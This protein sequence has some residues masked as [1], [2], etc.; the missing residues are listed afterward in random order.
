MSR[1]SG[2]ANPRRKFGLT[3]GGAF[4][5]LGALSRLLGSGRMAPYVAALGGL[6]VVTG[7]LAPAALGPVERIWMKL[8]AL[9]HAVMS[10]VI[11]ALIFFLVVVP[12]A[13]ARRLLGHDSL[14]LKRTPRATYWIECEPIAPETMTRQF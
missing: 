13:L 10:V 6:L 12:I 14:K 3:V 5:V 9:M 8:A 4:L 7:I 1:P 2:S 11:V